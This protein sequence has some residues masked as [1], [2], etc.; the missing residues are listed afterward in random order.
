[1]NNLRRFYVVGWTVAFA[2]FNIISFVRPV[3]F[4]PSFWNGYVAITLAFIGHLICT[5]TAFRSE[6]KERLFYNLPLIT[7]SYAGLIIMLVAGSLT[8]AFPQIPY[9]LGIIL[10]V[11][12]LGLTALSVIKARAAG[13]VVFG[14]DEAVKLKTSFIRSLL[15]DAERLVERSES[16]EAL[17]ASKKVC[18]AIRY[19]DPVSN[20]ELSVIESD[21]EVAFRSFEN[22]I[23]NDSMEDISTASINLITLIGDRNR[24]NRTLK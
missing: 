9:W 23:L 13:E 12:I 20:E 5:H 21:I 22:A 14:I 1:M 18:D 24:K 15:V 10:C 11:A 8:M 7:I 4:D 16:K 17:A 3:R 6:N 2:V 19:S